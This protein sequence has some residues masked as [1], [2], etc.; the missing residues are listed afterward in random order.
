MKEELIDLLLEY[1]GELMQER[2]STNSHNW[3][4]RDSI[5]KKMNAINLLLNVNNKQKT[6]I[7]LIWETIKQSNEN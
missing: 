5:I 2:D 7:T 1:Y 4:K 6:T 3:P